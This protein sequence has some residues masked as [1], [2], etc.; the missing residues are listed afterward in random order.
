MPTLGEAQAEF[1]GAVYAVHA[2][3]CEEFGGAAG[4]SKE[5]KYALLSLRGECL[6]AQKQGALAAEAFGAAAQVD[7]IDKKETALATGTDEIVKRSVNL[8][9]VPLTGKDK[10]PLPIGDKTKRGPALMAYF[11]DEFGRLLPDEAAAVKSDEL[12][13]TMDFLPKLKHV[14]MLEL[15]AT[16]DTVQTAAWQRAMAE[17][18]RDLIGGEIRT[19][20]TEA[21]TIVTAAITPTTDG[22]GVRHRKGLTDMDRAKLTDILSSCERID[23]R[24]KELAAGLG[25]DGDFFKTELSDTDALEKRVKNMFNGIFRTAKA[26]AAAAVARPAGN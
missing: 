2:D 10:K 15:A 8:T 18:A 5:D 14:I 21:D 24:S 25:T 3:D 16:G 19:M 4:A 6:L 17:H 12:D 13:Q 11:T 23:S 1:D 26:A 9:Y 22:N 7:G 20:N